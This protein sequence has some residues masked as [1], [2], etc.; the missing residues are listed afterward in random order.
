MCQNKNIAET[1]V[2]LKKKV[3]VTA[4]LELLSGLHIGGS[5]D[6]VEIGGIDNIVIR[7][8]KVGSDKKIDYQPYIPG[9]SLKGKMRCLLEQ[10]AGVTE[11]GGGED[12]NQIDKCD[13]INRLFGITEIK[14]NDGAQTEP[15][16]YSRRTRLIVRDAYIDD[17]CL[18]AL[19]DCETISRY[20]ENKTEN[21][22]DR[23]AG[24]AIAP[25]VMERI[26]AGVTFNLEFVV[27]LWEGDDPK[28]LFNTFKSGLDALQDDYLGGSGTRGCGHIKIIDRKIDG[29]NWNDSNIQNLIDN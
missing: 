19:R 11:V 5:S 13:F 3:K 23:V 1:A 21:N 20:T 26:P 12:S 22:I 16:R 10:M 2:K 29:N 6:S 27:N 8:A 17:T 15:K 25:R 18:Q 14:S 24:T 28:E 9:S 7:T 4:K